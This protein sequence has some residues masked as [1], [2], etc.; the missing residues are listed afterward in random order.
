MFSFPL[1]G[2][3]LSWAALTSLI[4]LALCASPAAQAQGTQTDTYTVTYSGGATTAIGPT[5]YPP[6]PYTLAS[7][8]DQHVPSG[9]AYGGST[10]NHYF[11]SG[12]SVT[13]NCQGAITATFT[14]NGGPNNDPAPAA[15]SVIVVEQVNADWGGQSGSVGSDI[16]GGT[17]TGSSASQTYTAIRYSV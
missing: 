11:T 2:R 10:S 12:Q 13:L 7:A 5:D 8:P 15:N 14:W 4:S 3:P 17:T 6:G 1:L 16:P 9:N